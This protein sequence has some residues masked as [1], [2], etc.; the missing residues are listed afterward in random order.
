[1]V[2]PT[3]QIT[4]LVGG[5][6]GGISSGITGFV[7]GERGWKLARTVAVGATTGAIASVLPGAKA[8][9]GAFGGGAA[10]GGVVNTFEQ[11]VSGTPFSRLNKRQIMAA[12]ANGAV[13]GLFGGATVKT[14]QAARNMQMLRAVGRAEIAEIVDT[15]IGTGMGG[16]WDLWLALGDINLQHL[17]VGAV[18]L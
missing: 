10:T 5:F 13:T 1:M 7:R 9:L 2:D 6:V 4:A 12:G 8:I 14:L 3:G 16:L 15:A 17:T 11:L 18:C